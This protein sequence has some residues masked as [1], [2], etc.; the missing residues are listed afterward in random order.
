MHIFLLKKIIMLFVFFSTI[1]SNLF[2]LEYFSDGGQDKYVNENFFSNKSEG[3]FIDIG[4]HEGIQYSN[5]YFFEK[6]LHWKGI[7]FEPN[8]VTFK[9]LKK[10]R[11]CECVNAA[12]SDESGK[13]SFVCHPCSWV[14]GLSSKYSEQHAKKWHV[15]EEIQNRQAQVI[16]VD[17]FLLNNILNERN[18]DHVDLLSIDTEGGELEILKSINFDAFSIDVIVVENIYNDTSYKDFLESVGYQC[19]TKLLRDEIYKKK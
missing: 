6:S 12:I 7:C 13:F 4:A 5:T 8:P 17:C 1:G 10:N 18:I 2:S 3:F 14:S 11:S 16:Q 19:V 9:K 15:Q